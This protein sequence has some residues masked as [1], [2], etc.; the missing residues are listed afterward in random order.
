MT[1]RGAEVAKAKHLKYEE[2]RISSFIAARPQQTS[3]GY[4]WSR[5][6]SNSTD[7]NF[8]PGLMSVSDVHISKD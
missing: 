1:K 7:C 8:L 3:Q 5:K 4:L 2:S 6:C